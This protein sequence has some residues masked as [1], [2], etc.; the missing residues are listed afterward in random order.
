MRTA[1]ITPPADL[2]ISVL[3]ARMHMRNPEVT[4]ND[5]EILRF[6]RSAVEV[7]ENKLGRTLLTQTWEAYLDAFPVGYCT[8]RSYRP[9]FIELPW[10]PAQSITS[11]KYLDSSNVLQTM[12]PEDYL[13]DVSGELARVRPAYGKNWPSTLYYENAVTVRWVAGYADIDLIPENIL[14]WLTAFVE[15]ADKNRGSHVERAPQESL[16]IDG[17][18]DRY[19]VI[20]V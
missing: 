1:R 12:P 15:S 4:D 18:L 14:H 10:P 7:G 6:I 2:P 17:L 13:L 8:Q 9:P 5:S 16:F 3:R 11:V 19:K 20:S